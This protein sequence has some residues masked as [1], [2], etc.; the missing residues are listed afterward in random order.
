M[1][2]KVYKNIN[3]YHFIN[4]KIYKKTLVSI[5]HNSHRSVIRII[6]LNSKKILTFQIKLK[7]IKFTIKI[8]KIKTRQ[9]IQL[10]WIL[11]DIVFQIITWYVSILLI[12]ILWAII[13]FKMNCIMVN[14]WVFKKIKYNRQ[15]MNHRILI[16][17]NNKEFH[18]QILKKLIQIV[19]I[20][21]QNILKLNPQKKFNLK[22]IKCKI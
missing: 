11:L 7:V 22:E 5:N 21:E 14:R 13:S 3:H 10:L 4:K 18:Y 19:G 16:I 6:C 1:N 15:F 8:K 2:I 12:K 9:N 20:I 17:N